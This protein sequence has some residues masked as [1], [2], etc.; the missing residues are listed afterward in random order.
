MF[1]T[2]SVI[3]L[4]LF[5]ESLAA[6]VVMAYI[7]V[8]CAISINRCLKENSLSSHTKKLHQQMFF[9]LLVEVCCFDKFRKYTGCG[10]SS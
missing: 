2:I 1:Q 3:E 10:S 4:A 6:V 9:L 7:C 5:G 8:R